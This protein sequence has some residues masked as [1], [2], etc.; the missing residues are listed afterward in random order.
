MPAY[1]LVDVDDLLDYLQAQ[2]SSPNLSDAVATLRQTAALASGLSSAERL[3][4]IAISDWNKYHRPTRTG[5]NVQ[6]IFVAAGYD[7]F[8]ITERKFMVDALLTQFFPVEVE[9]A[10]DEL[11]LSTSREDLLKI[12]NRMQLKP[13]TRVRVWSDVAFAMQGVIYQPLESILG[14]Q[15]K[16]VALYIDFENITISLNEQGYIVD[17]DLLLIGVKKRAQHY[18]QLIHMAA[19]APWGQRGSLPPMLDSQG[20]E[21][22]DDVPSRMAVESIDPVFS[23]PGKNSADLRIAKDVLAES[24]MPG[25]AEVIIIASGD[26]DFN[27]IYNTLRARGKQVIVWGVRGSTSRVLENNNSIVLE[28][29]DDFI[30]F[31]QHKELLNIFQEANHRQQQQVLAQVHSE[32][33]NFRPSPWSSVVLQMDYLTAANPGRPITRLMLG[34][35][36]VKLHITANDDRAQDLIDQAIKIGVLDVDEPTDQ[37]TVQDSNPI[38]NNTRMIRD[39]IVQRVNNT[40]Q[41]RQWDYVNYGFLLKGIAMDNELSLPGVNIDDN[42]R[43]EWID[44]LVRENVLV[45]ELIPHRHNPDDLVPVIRVP[46]TIIGA[47][48]QP[49][50]QDA[51]ADTIRDMS[52]RIVVSVEQFTSFRKFAWCPLGSLHKRL[53]PFDTGSA[54]QQAVEDLVEH[55]AVEIGEYPNPQSTFM[56]KGV[57]LIE[58]APLSQK[59]L[60]ERNEFIKTLLDYYE[61]RVPITAR[62]LQ[63]ATGM[64]ERHLELWISIME[65][66]NVLNPVPGHPG[67]FSLF[68]THHT[69]SLVAKDQNLPDPAEN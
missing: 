25:S 28:Y 11:I 39:H 64:E 56:T 23:L 41:V 54:F 18:G 50:A 58:E 35:Q 65:V 29:L 57:S 55:G 52:Y 45:R 22:S 44:F 19:Y 1:L 42:W 59:I 34:Q 43:S 69:V 27:D 5:V 4:A 62:V 14:V 53:R 16:S 68:R 36:F 26:R 9:A 37:L 7:L 2:P 51:D 21:I 66:E 30:K 47:N 15:T 32:E 17:L 20:R 3:N 38:V 60:N 67:V 46:T 10:I 33:F 61:R 12:V 31:R 24:T 49:Q 13:H 63:E 8:N 48:L 6:Q 40:L